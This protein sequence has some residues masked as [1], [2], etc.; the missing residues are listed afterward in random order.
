MLAP[1]RRHVVNRRWRLEVSMR[2]IVYVS[3]PVET[4]TPQ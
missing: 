3:F 1:P 4:L 2:M